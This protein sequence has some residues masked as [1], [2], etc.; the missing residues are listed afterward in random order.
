MEQSTVIMSGT[1]ISNLLNSLEVTI[2]QKNKKIKFNKIDDYKSSNVSEK[3]PRIILSYID[4]IN[5]KIWFKI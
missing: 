4:Q 5:K 3:I 1:K 2:K